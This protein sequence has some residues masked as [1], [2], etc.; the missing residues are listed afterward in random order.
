MIYSFENVTYSKSMIYVP[1]KYEFLIQKYDFRKK[2][3]NCQLDPAGRNAGPGQTLPPTIGFL[4]RDDD[5][6]IYDEIASQ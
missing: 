3:N 1:Q 5:S 2:K 6:Y 4:H